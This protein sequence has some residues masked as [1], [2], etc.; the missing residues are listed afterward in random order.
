MLM[1]ILLILMHDAEL[2]TLAQRN[3]DHNSISSTCCSVSETSLHSPSCCSSL[4]DNDFYV[5]SVDVTNNETFHFNLD[6]QPLDS[7]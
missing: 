2:P 4:W 5:E 3:T 6:E 7:P 1:I